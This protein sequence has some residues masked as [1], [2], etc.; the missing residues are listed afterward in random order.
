MATA[1][2]SPPSGTQQGNFVVGITFD[3]G[4]I[5]FTA[6]TL[7]VTAVSGNGITGVTFVVLPDHDMDSSTYNVSFMLPEDVQ[8]SLQIDITGMVTR[9]GSRQ[10]EAV[11]A[12]AVTVAYDNTSNISVTFGQV[13]YRDGGEIVVPVTVAEP[14][15]VN[16]KTVF[17]ITSVDDSDLSGIAYVLLGEDDTYELI[18]TVPPDRRGS[19]QISADGNVWKVAT[20]TWDN[21]VATPLTV[22]FNT[23]VPQIVDFDIPAF[24]EA[25]KK[26]YVR[27]AL[28]TLVTGWH[29]N[30]T[31]TEIFI[32]EGARL[33][34]PLPYKW[35]GTAAPD[36][37]A[38]LP[39][40]L[41]SDWQL[42]ASPPGGHQGPWHGEEGQYFLIEF[43]QVPD[44]AVG[45]YQMS[46][47][48]N[49]SLRG[50]VS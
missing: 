49:S 30:N 4:L 14:V 3:V 15:I 10:P 37:H 11:V 36:I 31:F 5:D 47:R 43:S 6:D 7:S 33:G 25:G 34:T 45:N 20:G 16:A 19:F 38:P 21:I 40:P 9:V 28:N 32:E 48:P 42:L 35:V 2:I 29:L 17:P 44:T 22:A 27:V 18:V 46:L 39:D 1:T 50:P 8:G 12:T 24:F 23:A 13:A 41:P 26:F